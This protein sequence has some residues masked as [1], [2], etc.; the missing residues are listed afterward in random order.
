MAF[1]GV[2][3]VGDSRQS[4]SPSATTA[5]P[6]SG[7]HLLVVHGYSRTK[8]TPN[9]EGMQSRPFKI[10]GYRWYIEYYPND[11]L[12][13]NADCIS[14]YLVFNESCTIE[15]VTVKYEFSF[16]DQVQKDEPPLL[17]RDKVTHRFSTGDAWSPRCFMKREVFEKSKHIKNDSFTIRCDIVVI[18][19]KDVSTKDTKTSE[20]F[21]VVPPVD[22]QQ[23]LGSL[24]LSEEGTDVMFQ[25][26]S[27]IFAAHR[28]VLAARSA[29]FKALLFGPM[30]EGATKAVTIIEDMEA[31]VFKLLLGFLY[32]D[33]VPEI[34]GEDE[35]VMWQHLLVAA[36]RYVLS[37]LKLICEQLLCTHINTSTVKNILALAE[38]RHCQGLK[39]ACLDFLNSS[40]NLQEV[41]ASGDL[42]H[43]INSCPSV[44]K[45][46]IAKL[47]SLK[48]DNLY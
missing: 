29:V 23:H 4:P 10:G 8:D 27:E 48:F 45:E 26:G 30:K 15:P 31:P 40:A 19:S 13:K 34:E 3:F 11:Y 44:L 6:S 36:D 37:R 14:F 33:Q 38:Q 24:F 46:L 35:A 28:C 21:V 39:D 18:T 5:V 1:T 47:A 43:L 42:D 22:I 41:M 2:S 16:V 17:V 32:S 25:V 7:H 20:P 9:G 12:P